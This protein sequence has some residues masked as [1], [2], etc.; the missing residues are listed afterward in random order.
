ML[1]QEYFVD[2]EERDPQVA[3]KKLIA[4]RQLTNYKIQPLRG[5]SGPGLSFIGPACLL[6]P[7]EGPGPQFVVIAGGFG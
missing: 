3:A 1:R 6:V 2:R 5:W 4:T 7:R